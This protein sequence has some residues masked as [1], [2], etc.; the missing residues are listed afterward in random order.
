MMKRIIPLCLFLFLTLFI[1]G[2]TYAQTGSHCEERG[3]F[4]SPTQGRVCIFFPCSPEVVQFRPADPTL[5]I[6]EEHRVEGPSSRCTG[7]VRTQCDDATRIIRANHE[8]YERAIMRGFSFELDKHREW[9]LA[10]SY[11]HLTLP[12]KA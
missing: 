6:G 3:C 7:C 9:M 12:T 11:T 8:T 5:G 10:V 2:D 1:A 4:T